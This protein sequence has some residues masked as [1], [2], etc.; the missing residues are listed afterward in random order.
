MFTVIHCHLSFLN[1][2]V[3]KGLSPVL[4]SFTHL[5]LLCKMKNPCVC[6]WR[7]GGDRKKVVFH[8]MTVKLLFGTSMDLQINH[9]SSYKCYP[10]TYAIA[11]GTG[12][13]DH[14]YGVANF[15]NSVL[16]SLLQLS[17]QCN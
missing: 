17:L 4:T 9:I 14:E 8:K 16:A 5:H 7:G 13:L 10:N 3:I 6:V 15:A 12:A 2:T 1:V 11:L